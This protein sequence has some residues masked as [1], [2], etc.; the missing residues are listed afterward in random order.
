M[1]PMECAPHTEREATGKMIKKTFQGWGK[2][3]EKSLCWSE[4]D[5]P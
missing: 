5:A 2:E 3:G 4:N 1:W